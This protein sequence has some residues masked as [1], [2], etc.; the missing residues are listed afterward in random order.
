[1]TNIA[2]S[3]EERMKQVESILL[4]DAQVETDTNTIYSVDMKECVT[5]KVIDGNHLIVSMYE[6]VNTGGQNTFLLKRFR[7]APGIVKNCMNKGI[8]F[9][10]RFLANRYQ[11]RIDEKSQRKNSAVHAA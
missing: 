4:K 5:I 3:C 9:Y 2:Q 6:I 7:Y 10:G 8:R 1:M 11:K